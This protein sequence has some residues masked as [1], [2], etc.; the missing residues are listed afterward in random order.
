MEN[1]PTSFRLT[2]ECRQLIREMAAATGLGDAGV[3]ELAVRAL[4]RAGPLPRVKAPAAAKAGRAR[5]A[6]PRRKA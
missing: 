3:L 1:A 2:Q 4:Y 5:K 6:A